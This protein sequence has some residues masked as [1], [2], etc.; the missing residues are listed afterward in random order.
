MVREHVSPRAPRVSSFFQ[1]YAEPGG[2]SPGRLRRAVLRDL[3]DGHMLVHGTARQ[4]GDRPSRLASHRARSFV[5]ELKRQ[6]E[7]GMATP[8]ARSGIDDLSHDGSS[9]VSLPRHRY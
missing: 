4:A 9:R 6:G 1:N 3:L 8:L 5:A 2:H 7:V